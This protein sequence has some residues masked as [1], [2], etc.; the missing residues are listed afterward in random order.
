LTKISR[1][2]SWPK[3]GQVVEKEHAIF[4]VGI[5]L[6]ALALTSCAPLVWNSEASKLTSLDKK[7]NRGK[8]IRIFEGR[9]GAD[10]LKVM[11][12]IFLF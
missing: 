3:K 11:C 8:Y 7:E 4:G 9:C 2:G 1:I 6:P 12:S 5:L 10:F